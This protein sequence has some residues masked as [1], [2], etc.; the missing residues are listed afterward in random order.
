MTMHSRLTL[1]LRKFKLFVNGF[2]LPARPRSGPS[3]APLYPAPAPDA[4]LIV[5]NCS[6]MTTHRWWKK[7]TS[8]Y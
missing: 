7:R 1:R 2:R 6:P 3:G 5:M 4:T 8:T